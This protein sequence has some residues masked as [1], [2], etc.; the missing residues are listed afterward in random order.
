MRSFARTSNGDCVA[1]DSAVVQIV[2]CDTEPLIHLDAL[3]ALDFLNDFQSV[4]VP[5][6][7]WIEVERHRSD[8]FYR[9]IRSF[10]RVVP[11]RPLAPSLARLMPLH[12]GETHNWRHGSPPRRKAAWTVRANTSTIVNIRRVGWARRRHCRRGWP[13]EQGLEIAFVPASLQVLVLDVEPGGVLLQSGQG[14]MAPDGELLA[15]LGVG[16]TRLILAKNHIEA[17]MPVVL[18]PPVTTHRAGKASNVGADTADGEAALGADLA[19]ALAA[20]L[21]SCRAC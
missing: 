6:A 17:P 13:E 7:V 11:Q 1:K 15:D 3:D 9:T 16:Q 2:V 4:P 19:F 18:D 10:A 8:L 5:D 14:D 20:R 12:V 21:D